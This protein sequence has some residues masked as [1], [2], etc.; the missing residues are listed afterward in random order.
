LL[1]EKIEN[2]RHTYTR[3][4]CWSQMTQTERRSW[5]GLCKAAVAS[6]LLCSG[7][8]LAQTA[9]N[10]NVVQNA[11]VQAAYQAWRTVAQSEVNCIDQSLRAQKSNVRFL[12]QQGIG[13]SDA[14]IAKVRAAC[15]TQPSASNRSAAVSNVSPGGAGQTAGRE[16]WS[17]NGSILNSAA[18]GGSIKFFY[19][20]PRPDLEATG[21]RRGALFLEGKAFTLAG[22]ALNQRLVGTAYHFDSRCGRI[23]YKVD[24]TI[25]DNNHRLELQG[26][27]PR[28]DATCVVIA[29]EL[30]ALTLKSVAP[31]YAATAEVEPDKAVIEKAAD[32]GAAENAAAEMAAAEKAAL[33]EKAA[34]DKA[35]ADKAAAEKTAAEKAAAEKAAAEKAA[36]EKAA[37]DKAAADKAAAD[38]AAADK[39]A[40]DKA[41]AE[42]TATEKAAADKAATDKA[43]AE[44][45]AAEKASADKA[46]AA[47]LAADKAIAEQAAADKAAMDFQKT[48]ADRAKVDAIKAQADAERPRQEAE[49]TT[50][51]AAIASAAV[52]SRMSF[53]YG[54]ISGPVI[55][56]LGG[57][58]F[59]FL[60]RKT[61][62]PD[63][64]PKVAALGNAGRET[65]IEL[66]RLITTGAAGQKRRDGKQPDS[67][68]P[69]ASNGAHPSRP[70]SSSFPA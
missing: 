24:G 16:Y 66:D 37:A 45:A 47:K 22:S 32:R 5:S 1:L 62:I 53:I 39:A 18:E 69:N 56:C 35:A 2:A 57:V 8:A 31:A 21:V 64:K 11:K 49:R 33:A 34:A 12:I 68:P 38:K 3:S 58:V 54:L 55:F 17:F 36:T 28:V 65:R 27:K 50:A 42:K 43:A 13:P 40:A 63:A 46:A 23:P 70:A 15:R 52:E 48:N 60:N 19:F 67:A 9:N 14:V 59:L 26:Q 51:E 6:S 10:I 29:T 41:A 44:K 25:R 4:H 30:D 7:G 20:K 61:S